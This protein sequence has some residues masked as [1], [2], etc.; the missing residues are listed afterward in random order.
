MGYSGCASGFAVYGGELIA[1][2]R[3]PEGG[4]ELMATLAPGTA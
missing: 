4:L 2:S 3:R 1:R